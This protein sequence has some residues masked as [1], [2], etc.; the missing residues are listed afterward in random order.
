M[1]DAGRAFE[2]QD[3]RVHARGL[4]DASVFGQ[5]AVQDGQAAVFAVGVGHVA[6]ATLFHVGVRRCEVLSCE[7][8]V[9]VG[10]PPGAAR[11]RFCAAALAVLR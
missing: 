10:T 3:R 9:C 4:H 11:V 7:N 8:A 2:A 5:V 1:E 6:D